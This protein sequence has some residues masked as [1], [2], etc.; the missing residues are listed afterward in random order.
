MTM[1]PE[2][3]ALLLAER[4]RLI[5]LC[6]R[7]S[8]NPQAA[9]DLA[10]ETLLQAWRSTHRLCHTEQ[11]SA[12]LS[13]IARNVCLHWSRRYY[14]E[15]AQHTQ[16]LQ[17][18]DDGP[19]RSLDLLPDSFELEYE[20]E[21]EE[22]ATLLDR[23]LALLPP[24]TRTVLVQKYIEE[25][26]H[27]EIA[28]H[29]GLSENAVAVRV[30]RGKLAFR[31]VLATELRHEAASY[32]LV[33]DAPSQWIETRMWC[34]FCGQ[35]RL[36][37]RRQAAPDSISFRCPRCAPT[38]EV[39]ESHFSLTNTCFAQLIG[40]LARPTS[41]VNRTKAWAHEYFTRALAEQSVPCTN[42][43][44]RSRLQV[45]VQTATPPDRDSFPLLLV[46]CVACGEAVSQSFTGFLAALPQVRTFW[47]THGRIRMLPHQITTADERSVMV[48]RFE[49]LVSTDQLHIVAIPDPVH[50]LRIEQVAGRRR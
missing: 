36:L 9:E 26:P 1:P 46:E 33:E 2:F 22:L 35:G 12:W 5:R 47:H 14:R 28:A 19:E 44:R 32:G 45:L 11:L 29:L 20:L 4:P 30:H 40:R 39:P 13:A 42:C 37:I 3:E 48:A 18:D 25:L 38:P 7:L 16:P 50:V 23:A 41:I 10:Q 43:G 15:Q 6:S 49:S 17:P 8:G 21:R 34:L 31:R 27:A 24:E